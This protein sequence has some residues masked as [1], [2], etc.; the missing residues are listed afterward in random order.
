MSMDTTRNI[1]EITGLRIE[2]AK[3]RIIK[4]RA[5]SEAAKKEE[6]RLK[7]A[8]TE[9]E[10]ASLR[11]EALEEM[12]REQPDAVRA[13]KRHYAEA[14]RDYRNARREAEVQ[15]LMAD[16]LQAEIDDVGKTRVVE[17]LIEIEEQYLPEAVEAL[18]EALAALKAAG[19]A[20]DSCNADFVNYKMAAPRI[21]P[22]NG[23]IVPILNLWGTLSF[24]TNQ[25][26][27]GGSLDRRT[28]I[29]H[30]RE[31]G[32]GAILDLHGLTH[33]GVGKGGAWW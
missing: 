1:R 20:L 9:A 27:V 23:P 33:D 29:D 22:M 26:G 10:D 13:A 11:M 24:P 32:Y 15:R 28:L 18:I 21:I 4:H 19:D 14:D 8:L 3:G 12:G 30:L 7:A 5:Q 6:V 17:T 2:G 16:E 25:P 31:L